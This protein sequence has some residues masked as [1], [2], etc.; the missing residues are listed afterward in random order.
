MYIRRA[1][2]PFNEPFWS[3][4]SG[5]QKKPALLPA[6]L[7]LA[8][9]SRSSPCLLHTHTH[10]HIHT[11]IHIYTR[12]HKRTHT[13]TYLFTFFSF[14]SPSLSLSLPPFPLSPHPN[15]PTAHLVVV[16]RH[17][18]LQKAV[19]LISAQRR[20]TPVRLQDEEERNDKVSLGR[21]QQ[22]AFADQ[23]RRVGRRGLPQRRRSISQ[24]TRETAAAYPS[25]LFSG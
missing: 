7:L 22:S 8:S 5:H 11:Y 15:P 12:T 17:T 1:G 24:S 14:L 16:Q 21:S 10:T 4:R 3:T 6:S 25:S 13:D 9:L 23:W 19:E 2:E 18:A 20:R